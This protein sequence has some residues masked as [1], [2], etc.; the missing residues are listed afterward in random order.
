MGFIAE[1]QCYALATFYPKAPDYPDDVR[2]IKNALV[3]SAY[4]ETPIPADVQRLY[5]WIET[6]NWDKLNVAYSS[7][8]VDSPMRWP[9]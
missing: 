8:I 1:A 4:G 9:P 2:R 7:A 6:E 5:D 3:G